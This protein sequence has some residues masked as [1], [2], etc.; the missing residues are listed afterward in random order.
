[1]NRKNQKTGKKAGRLS[2][3]GHPLHVHLAR[4]SDALR[5]PFLMASL[6]PAMAAGAYAWQKGSF[7]AV[8]FVLA[9]LA[10]LLA[11]AGTNLSNDYYDYQAG[12]YPQKKNGPTGGS[13]AIQQGHYRPAQILGLAVLCFMASLAFFLY[14]SW[15]TASLV[16]PLGLAGIL[17]GFFY[18][19]PPLKF[20]YR[21]LGEITTFAGMG[22]L[23]FATVYLA[24]A[25]ALPDEAGWLL[26]IFLGVLVLNVL[27][28]AQ[29]PD[30]EIDRLSRKRTISVH[31][32]A[33]ALAN[34]YGLG[35]LMAGLAL[36]GG[37]LLHGLPPVLLLGLAGLYFSYKAYMELKAERPLAAL[38]LSLTA[39][40][41]GAGIVILALLLSVTFV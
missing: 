28:A 18:T 10:V 29:V 36:A 39:L 13:F 21:L 33:D 3:A 40:Q 38:G 41:A 19:A 14:L 15:S 37:V 2:S 35:S 22:P 8:D 1:M 12:N 30:I 7:D 23:L 9:S 34:V 11:H 5:L 27:L 32:G 17:L 4:L 20:G 31:W 24:A 26:S 25:G 16:F 6:L